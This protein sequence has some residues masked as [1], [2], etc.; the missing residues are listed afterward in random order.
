MTLRVFM[1]LLSVAVLTMVVI[2]SETIS[3]MTPRHM[4]MSTTVLVIIIQIVLT[5]L[6][7]AC[8]RHQ[9]C[10]GGEGPCHGARAD[11]GR[12]PCCCPRCPEGAWHAWQHI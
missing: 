1:I 7:S 4:L 6:Q 12:R 5:L 3:T 8:D 9:A 10:I 11:S 2:R